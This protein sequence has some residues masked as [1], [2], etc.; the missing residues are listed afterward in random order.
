MELTETHREILYQAWLLNR[1]AGAGQVLEDGAIPDAHELAEA[2]WLKRRIQDDQ[3]TW[4]WS[5]RAETA[6]GLASL[7]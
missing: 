7:T 2:G 5:D 1:A 4:W 3:V 6:L